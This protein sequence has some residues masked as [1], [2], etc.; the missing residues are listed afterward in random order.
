MHEISTW[1][2]GLNDETRGAHLLDH[3]DAFVPED[4]A[5]LATSGRRP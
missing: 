5:R 3:A 1:S 4:A 2:P